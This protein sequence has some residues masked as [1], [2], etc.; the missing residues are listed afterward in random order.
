MQ[1]DGPEIR[2][3]RERAGYGLRR[4]AAAAQMSP[5][6]L[7]RIERG[8]SDPQP[9]V[10]ARIAARLDCTVADLERHRE[11]EATH[12]V[13]LHDDSGARGPHPA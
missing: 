3:Q 5:S 10:L 9:E 12:G 8:Q 11:E 4:F 2:R 6:H 7:S 1:A 13:A